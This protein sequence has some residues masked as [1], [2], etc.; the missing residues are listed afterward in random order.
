[1]GELK[2]QDGVLGAE[3]GELADA[4]AGDGGQEAGKGEEVAA[5]SLAPL[6]DVAALELEDGLGGLQR[7]GGLRGSATEE[8]LREREGS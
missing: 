4:A 8:L 7:G 6:N 1:M 3:V 5:L 2:V